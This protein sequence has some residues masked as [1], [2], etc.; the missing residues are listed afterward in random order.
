M[1]SALDTIFA[2]SSGGLPAAV[3]VVRISGPGSGLA[4]ETMTG[5]LPV[6]RRATLRG[7][8]IRKQTRSSTRH[9]RCGFP[10][11]TAKP[12][13]TP[14]SSRCMAAGRWWRRCFK[15]WV[16]CPGFVWP[17][18]ANSPAA[19]SRSSAR[20]TQVE[21]L[22]DLVYAETA[23]Q[24]RQAFEQ[25]S[26]LLGDRA[27]AWRTQAVEAL[28]LIE[29]GI[30]FSDEGD[31]PKDLLARAL[32]ISG[33]L[34]D[35]IRQALGGADRGE[36]LREGL[37]VVIAGPP[38]V[39]K[40]TL[41]NAL[42]RREA[43][44]VSPIPGTTRDVIE[45]HLDLAGYPVNL[46]DTAGIREQSEDP[47]EREGVRRARNIAARADLVLWLV[48][49]S[50]SDSPLPERVSAAAP[51]WIVASKA[52][53]LDERTRPRLEW[54]LKR[55]PEV[56][57]V[58]AAAG[59]G[60]AGL[61]AAIAHFA[62]RHFTLEPALVTR[63]RQRTLLGQT[64]ER[65]TEGQTLAAQSAGEELVAEQLRL[66]VTSLGRL[67]G[68]VDVEEVLGTIFSSS[69]LENNWQLGKSRAGGV[70]ERVTPL[71]FVPKWA[72]DDVCE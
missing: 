24:R 48:D 29:A 27:E 62:E 45:I 14:P 31:V 1:T 70:L 61:I 20:F 21:A 36:R 12:V 15:R 26:G 37:W 50:V 63:E 6:A 52:D 28:A 30:D 51:H 4:L 66:A 59:T 69:A 34:A 35:E 53:L 67:T 55:W 56:H 32:A 18:L 47:I 5:R 13:R 54:R 46:I 22:A 2:L 44:I 40:S 42:A 72:V 57:Y 68:R 10:A 49:A 17:N 60:L 16:G 7:C 3:A 19:L 65:L 71:A 64:V 11:R 58:S 33:P 39:G 41:L 43:A 9:W 23:A 38:N 8:A 25:F